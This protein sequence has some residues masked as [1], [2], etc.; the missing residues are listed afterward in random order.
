M[1]SIS[2][3]VTAD[4]LEFC[5]SLRCDF[6]Q[7]FLLQRHWN[8]PL[9]LSHHLS[10]ICNFPSLIWTSISTHV[11]EVRLPW[12]YRPARWCTWS[13]EDKRIVY[14]FATLQVKGSFINSMELIIEAS[15][16]LEVLP[17]MQMDTQR[18]GAWG[19]LNLYLRRQGLQNDRTAEIIRNSQ[20]RVLHIIT[21]NRSKFR[22]HLIS[23][24]HPTNC[25][26]N[27]MI[28]H[29]EE[30]FLSSTAFLYFCLTSQR[31]NGRSSSR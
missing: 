5:H 17:T 31:L 9:N 30:F 1:G 23:T 10:S 3:G 21:Q 16:N 29:S 19:C 18:L 6:A 26:S 7:C 14:G 20:N 2:N 25:P 13:V 8:V 24:I 11:T 27:P 4:D 12:L 15:E 28:P 22:N